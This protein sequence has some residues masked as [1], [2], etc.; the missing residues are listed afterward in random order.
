MLFASTGEW[1]NAVCDAMK[2]VKTFYFFYFF[3]YFRPHWP[4]AI[5]YYE[6]ITQSYALAAAIFSV[7]FISQSAL[8]LPTAFMSDTLGRKK[9]LSVGA[10][11]SVIGVLLYAIGL[12]FWV[13]VAGA[14]FEGLSRALFSGTA[15][16]L[17]FET[18]KE[19]NLSE[20]FDT[21][22]GKTNTALQAALASSAAFGSLLA[23]NS[24]SL[25]VWVAVIPQ[26]LCLV[27]TFFF[28]EPKHIARNTEKA[29]TLFINAFKDIKSNYKLRLLG[30]AEVLD[31]GFGEALF[32]FQGAFYKQLIPE[33]MIGIAKSV[34]HCL[35]ATGFW[36]SGAIIKK[37]G[38]RNTLL[39]STAASAGIQY[40]GIL[41]ATAASPFILALVAIF[42]G[43]SETARSSLM[44]M[45]F[46][47]H[48]RATMDS[49]VSLVGSFVF[50]A[51]SFM[52]GLIADYTSPATA[53]L[54]GVTVNFA[55]MYVYLKV[56]KAQKN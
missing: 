52:L 23:L 56:F 50:G 11:F 19:S 53:M 15:K 31:F 9:T 51:A 30:V 40:A 44:Q 7:V 5:I 21:I 37:L 35:S 10:F 46:T 25:V 27:T 47:D 28:I 22:Y 43:P 33:W 42:F 49:W 34:T 32:Y 17:L 26:V 29:V 39:S 16:A 13:L 12:N 36:F 2:N 4:I 18:L 14:I 24:L 45:E 48:Q 54:I 20:E 3:L 1:L 6:G 41:T 8:E 55:T 38:Y